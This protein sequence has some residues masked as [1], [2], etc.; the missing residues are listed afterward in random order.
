VINLR[1]LLVRPRAPRWNR[2]VGSLWFDTATGQLVRA[3]Y[4]LSEPLD[5]F[6]SDSTGETPAFVKAAL[7]PST[8]SIVGV[9]VEYGLHQGRYWL[10]R[11]QAAEGEVRAGFVRVPIRIEERFTYSSVNTDL[12]ITLPSV[13]PR[14][15]IDT[16]AL[17]GLTGQEHERRYAELVRQRDSLRQQQDAQQCAQG[18]RMRRAVRHDGTLPVVVRISCDSLAL[19][20]SPALPPSIFD[21]GDDVFGDAERDALLAKA[22]A[23]V[24]EDMRNLLGQRTPQLRWG[25]DLVRYNRVEGL[26]SALSIDQQI[27]PLGI[28]MLRVRPRIGTADRVFNYDAELRYTR[29]AGSISLIGYKRLV[30]A[31]DWGDPLSFGSAASAFLF[32]R[33]EGL[34]YRATGGELVAQTR[35]GTVRIFAEKQSDALARTKISVPG[36]VGATAFDPDTNIRADHA[37]SRG[38]SWR[39]VRSFGA[40][41]RGWRLDSDLRTEAAFGDFEYQR[42]ALDLT[43][44]HPLT[45]TVSASVTLGGGTSGGPVPVQRRYYIGGSSTVRGQ[46]AGAMSGDAY[47]LA[48]AEV[49]RGAAARRVLFADFGWAGERSS[50][51]YIR[52]PAS[53]V[54]AGFSLLDGVVRFDIAR[55]LYPARQWRVSLYMDAKF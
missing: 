18:G 42:L 24:P 6:R 2:V 30:A 37:T 14:P 22:M 34:Y 9:A 45:R 29:A 43:T 46:P 48:R 44:T 19:A 17:A 12:A 21:D 49:G 15:S 38:G 33:D 53:G 32:G 28:A 3:A 52:R 7:H 36:L 31:N 11:T 5:L 1:E 8:A 4:K 41:P 35:A 26:S 27:L 50:W 20:N 13:P 23:M 40:D 47:W 55:G 54:G 25:L 16:S 51:M 39:M 10:P